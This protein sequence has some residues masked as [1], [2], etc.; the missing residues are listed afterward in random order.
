M[1]VCVFVV[2]VVVVVIFLK[3]IN[4]I[5]IK[6][7]ETSVTRNCTFHRYNLT[8]SIGLLHKFVSVCTTFA[9]FQ[10]GFKSR[11]VGELCSMTTRGTFR[12]NRQFVTS[13]S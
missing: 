11:G 5:K 6:S 1:L 2:V 12:Y 10:I 7:F 4:N 13:S 3:N 8:N 9:D